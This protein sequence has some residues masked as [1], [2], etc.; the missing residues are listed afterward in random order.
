M[1][2]R[3]R[4]AGLLSEPANSFPQPLR[5]VT[6][7]G[8]EHSEP[9]PQPWEKGFWKFTYT[10]KRPNWS[11]K[12][13]LYSTKAWRGVTRRYERTK[14]AHGTFRR[15]W[16]SGKPRSG[17]KCVPRQKDTELRDLK[18]PRHRSLVW[19]MEEASPFATMGLVDFIWYCFRRFIYLFW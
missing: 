9:T 6:A 2:V 19:I 14:E 13:E 18:G 1:K 11:E 17:T 3:W 16:K 7:V 12:V 8:A 10:G 4:C 15:P 5:E